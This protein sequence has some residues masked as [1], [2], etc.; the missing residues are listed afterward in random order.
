M[1]TTN[2]EI[3][4]IGGPGPGPPVADLSAVD[5]RTT[6]DDLGM[7]PVHDLAQ[8]VDLPLD[9][10]IKCKGCDRKGLNRQFLQEATFQKHANEQHSDLIIIWRCSACQKGFPK[11]HGCRCHLPKCKGRQV[12]TGAAMIKCDLCE[13]AFETRRGV[14]MHERHRHPELRNTR[15][16]E[17][18]GS[19]SRNR[20]GNRASAWSQEEVGLLIQL[21]ERF[22][23]LKQPN[24]AIR[25]F[26]PGKTLKQISDK[27]RLLP[28]QE[29]EAP[30]EVDSQSE[31]SSE[32]Y[33]SADDA[34]IVEEIL[35]RDRESESWKAP[36]REA[37][38]S[39]QLEDESLLREIEKEIQELAG[40]EDIEEREINQIVQTFTHILFESDQNCP[41]RGNNSKS[42]TNKNRNGKRQ[43]KRTKRK[44]YEYSR[45][46]ELYRKCP[47]KLLDLAI[48]G[49]SVSDK[50]AVEPPCKSDVE[51]LY[52]DLWGK[53]GPKTN[54][55]KETANITAAIK[56]EDLWTPVDV[57][58]LI[59]KFK[60]I[61][62]KTA[63]GADGIEKAHLR[64]RGALFV[65]A[66]L[67]NLLMMSRVYP[68]QWK[69]NRTTLIPKPGK[70]VE[71]VANWR[72]IT[73][74]SLLGRLYSAMIDKRI[75]S[76]TSQN[77][78]QKGFTK[79]D[80]CKY[81]IAIL[82]SALATIKEKEGGIIVII[83]ISKAF[84]TVPHKALCDAL[85]VKG[86]PATIG[87]YI[88]EMYNGCKTRISCKGKEIVDVAL[89][90]G[91]K[92]GDP[93]SP[94]LFNLI[95]DPIIGKID[96]TSE[97]V[98]VGDERISIMAFADDL[99][100]LAKTKEEAQSQA[101]SI[102]TYLGKLG[103]KISIEKC[104]SF[105]VV[106]KNK[107]WHLQNPNIRLGRQSIPYADPDKTIEYLG[108]TVNPWH[109]LRKFSEKSLIEAMKTIKQMKLKP[110]QKVNLIRTYLLPRFTHQL[111]AN[112][113]SLGLLD[114][115]DQEV[116][117]II[118]DIL[119]LHP[120]TTDGLIYTEKSHGGL[121][122]QRVANIVRIAKLKNAIK[123]KESDDIIVKSAY[124]RQE[125]LVKKYARSVGLQWPANLEEIETIRKYL[126]R[127]DT[128]KWQN[129]ISQGQGVKE[130]FKDKIGNTWLYH[131]ELL[132]PSRYLDALKLRSNT[133]GTKVALNR[134]RKNLDVSCRRCGVQAETLGHSLM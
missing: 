67:C 65:L 125:G 117:G 66:K 114:R 63:A 48:S 53:P 104:L 29:Q 12:P 95:I 85:D 91:V 49:K 27:R 86:V 73:I 23:H 124:L 69:V 14:S 133:F 76:K 82:N 94:L 103:M 8:V 6:V 80:G 37:I 34:V 44:A 120:S 129:L 47:K 100:L 54:V 109:G 15:R 134:A 101:K 13:E 56:I 112:P 70:S 128:E 42:R 92:Q 108:A 105:Q 16:V 33:H 122:V 99:V 36:L 51:P 22:K 126:K 58:E 115:I 30:A 123:M 68:E 7:T 31:S 35:R 55:I 21:N 110:H 75:R 83:D 118:K 113:P 39:S 96:E 19:Q 9:G 5:R 90:R 10:Q 111:V 88:T 121:G 131:P 132:K 79:E 20:P 71:D 106:C 89:R 40:K 61:K 45:Y 130:F 41:A 46:Q 24:V 2:E 3:S 26:L 93:L 43:N 107:T 77:L 81:N 84:D 25:E 1:S 52:N 32:E 4:D 17:S 38:L 59:T 116:K 97:G 74:G 57:G 62:A 102:Y 50:E 72:P 28:V 87:K 98:R 64:K 127:K 60:K 78:R 119:H 11:L 18:Q